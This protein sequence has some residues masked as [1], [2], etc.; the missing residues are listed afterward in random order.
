VS[1]ATT[2][3]PGD[4]SA[5][6]RQRRAL[7][8]A[9]GAHILHDGYAD[10]LYLL[11]PVW[12][13]E[14]MMGYAEIGL[15]RG[16]YAGAM[17][18]FQVPASMLSAKFGGRIVL[19]LGTALAATGFLVAGMSGSLYGLGLALLIGGIGAST[20]HPIA[21][22]IVGRAFEGPGSRVALGTYNFAG[23]LG[24]VTFPALTAGLLALMA[25]RSAVSVLAAVGLIGAAIIFVLLSTRTAP[26]RATV[27]ADE[28]PRAGAGRPRGGFMLLFWIG[29]ID[30][31]TRMGFLTFL[32]FLLDAKGAST[33]TMGIALT[34]VFAGGAAGKLACGYIGSRLGVLRT[35]FLT[36]GLT[37][38][39]IVAILRLPIEWALPILPVI[40]IAL[41]GTSSVLY[42]T[43]PELV[44]PDQ[45]ERAFGLFYTGTIGGGAIAPIIYGLVSD[46][47]G[48]QA[49]M[50][51]IAGIVLTTLPLAWLLNPSISVSPNQAEP[52]SPIR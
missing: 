22:S 32:P 31:A 29:V 4:G 19:T 8:I 35:V 24:K 14:F 50:L 12:R 43:V 45:Q 15:L 20:Q 52:D 28:I 26:N 16:L 9:S 17:A 2:T 30:T 44:R 51:I 10:L 5:R 46:A 23:D 48:V 33:T 18:G 13:A 47:L 21:S 36:E 25:W 42:G 41:N 40:G 1:S 37:A 7:L 3:Q 11:L 27:P 38:V 39:G 34:L 6:N 49:M